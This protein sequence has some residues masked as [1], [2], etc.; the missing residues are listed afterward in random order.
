MAELA[1]LNGMELTDKVEAG[2]LIKVL[3]GEVR[4]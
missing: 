3:E 1:I 2:T 4:K